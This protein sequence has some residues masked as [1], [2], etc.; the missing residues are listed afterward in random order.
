MAEAEKNLLG[1]S[2]TELTAVAGYAGGLSTGK[3]ASRPGKDL[4]CY[5][6][7]QRLADYGKLGHGEVVG[8]FR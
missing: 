5:H 3:D 4:V 7:W 8:E 6:N 1:R 2:E